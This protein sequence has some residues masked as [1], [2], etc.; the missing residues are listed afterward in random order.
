[1]VTRLT[2]TTGVQHMSSS[3][4]E[5]FRRLEGELDK[6]RREIMEKDLRDREKE[7]DRRAK[8]QE[9]VRDIRP[10]MVQM[11]DSRDLAPAQSPAPN[12][13]NEYIPLA[14][15]VYYSTKDKQVYVMTL[16]S[17][18]AQSPAA[19]RP[20]P[21]KRPAPRPAPARR[22]PSSSARRRPGP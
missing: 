6:M 17:G 12:L 7:L 14:N 1:M 5:S 18:A 21:A 9:T 10:E 11:S 8:E 22:R 2:A 13:G 20:A 15:G 3:D 19:S 16:A 4:Q